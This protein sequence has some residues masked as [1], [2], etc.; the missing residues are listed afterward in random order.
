ESYWTYWHWFDQLANGSNT[1]E[2]ITTGGWYT[3][4][5]EIINRYGVMNEV[6]F[7]P[8]E[9][10][11]ESSPTQKRALA[12]MNESLKNGALKDPSA[13]RDR[14]LVRDELDRAFGLS[15]EV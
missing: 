12:T 9:Q 4:A 11:F 15:P 10:W 14:A 2:E 6:D 5:A 3:T 1:S 13:R 7:I 8:S